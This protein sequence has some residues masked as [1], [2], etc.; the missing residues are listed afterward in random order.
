MNEIEVINILKRYSNKKKESIQSECGK[1]R[2][3][4]DQNN[5]EYGHFLGSVILQNILRVVLRISNIKF[6]W[7]T[8]TK[9]KSCH[10]K[11]S[12]VNKA[13]KSLNYHRKTK[14]I[15]KPDLVVLLAFRP[16]MVKDYLIAK[17]NTYLNQMLLSI[18]QWSIVYL[19]Y[20]PQRRIQNIVKHLDE[21]FS[22]NT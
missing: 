15:Q 4:L 20:S 21:R 14:N 18:K 7:K 13:E 3:K 6:Y 9:P 12:L 17:L 5:S 10:W 2:E 22:K 11:I 8:T 1:M 16:S 19:I